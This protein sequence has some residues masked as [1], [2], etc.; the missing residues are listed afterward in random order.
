[1][2]NEWRRIAAGRSKYFFSVRIVLIKKHE[3]ICS[4]EVATNRH[5]VVGR[6][7]PLAMYVNVSRELKPKPTA[8]P[9]LI[10]SY[11][12]TDP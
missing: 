1:L 7:M 4:G 8:P 3:L 5:I 11:L 10:I 2:E 12:A 6:S 9:N